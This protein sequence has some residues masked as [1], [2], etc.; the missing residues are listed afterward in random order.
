MEGSPTRYENGSVRYLVTYPFQ[1]QCKRPFP[2]SFS[3]NE[4][5]AAEMRRL[6]SEQ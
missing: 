4:S 6:G 1:E 5:L 2:Y 3:L